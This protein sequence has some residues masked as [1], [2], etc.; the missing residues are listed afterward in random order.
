M[1]T[2]VVVKKNDEGFYD[3]GF[4][5]D[6]DVE[7]SESLDT[8]I[9]I[10]IFCEQRATPSE[11]PESNRRRGWQGNESTPGF[12]IGSKLWEFEQAK[13]TGSNL[14]QIGTIITN[15]LKWMIDQDISKSAIATAFFRNGRVEAETVLVRPSSQVD[16]S[17]FDIWDNTGGNL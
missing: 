7:T 13:I 4:T 14:S 3:I 17:L 12:E 11:M 10:S 5:A 16:K 6:G 9:L 1:T 15:S 8:A 2:D